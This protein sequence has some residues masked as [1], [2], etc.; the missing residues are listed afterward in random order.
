MDPQDATDREPLLESQEP[1]LDSRISSSST[2]ASYDIS[3][4][5]NIASSSSS[6]LV[7]RDTSPEAATYGRHLTW[8]SAYILLISRMLGSGIFATPGSIVRSVGSVGLSLTLWAIG[9]ILASCGLAIILELGCM[10]PR[11]G[12]EKVYLEFIYRH[13]KF[14]ASTLVAVQAVLLGFTASNCIVFGQYTLYALE[15]EPTPFKQRALAVGVL[16]AITLVHGVWMRAGIRIQ[17]WLGW[18][19]MVLMA[20]M[21]AAA[22]FVLFRGTQPGV[23]HNFRSWG[24]LWEG[25]TWNI[26]ILSTALFKVSYSFAGYGNVNNVLNEVRDPVR[27][28]KTAAPMALATVFVAYMVINVA[29]FL[30]LPIDEI[31]NSGELVA[32]L[33]FT[34]V[35]GE[36]T[37]RR[38]L[39]LMIAISAAGNV[40]VVTFALVSSY[41]LRVY[42]TIFKSRCSSANE[43]TRH[44]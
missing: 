22:L 13:P 10:L 20:V 43:L 24:N 19:K 4:G 7:E 33:F 31:K 8:S 32:A 40:M 39:P 6:S 2:L 36:N 1:P 17:N 11:S 37:G 3:S 29:Y 42:Q 28:L 41:L 16:T 25:S 30:I 5:E 27:T 14:L 26:G 12:G 38:L 44:V 9:A 15:I 34:A 18:M 21:I 35:F 23:G